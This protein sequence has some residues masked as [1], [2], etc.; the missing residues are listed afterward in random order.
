MKPTPAQRAVALE[1]WAERVA[2][3]DLIE[4]ETALLQTI[5]ELTQWRDGLDAQLA[6]ALIP[7]TYQRR[8]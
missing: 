7:R 4:A 2:P 3:T 1:T 5:A 8:T 6:N